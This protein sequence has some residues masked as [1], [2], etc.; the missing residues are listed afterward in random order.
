MKFRNFLVSGII[1]IKCAR[2]DFFSSGCSS[3]FTSWRR[4]TLR[5]VHE[6]N[7]ELNG[8]LID[9]GFLY[10]DFALR[11]ALEEYKEYPL[12]KMCYDIACQYIKNLVPRF[13][14]SFADFVSTVELMELFTPKLHAHGHTDNCRYQFALDFADHVGRTHGERI[15]SC[16]AEANR[17]WPEYVRDESRAPQR[18]SCYPFQRLE[19]FKK[20]FSFVG[21]QFE[22]VVLLILTRSC[23]GILGEVA[24][25][26]TS[27]F[28]RKT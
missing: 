21:R 23:S 5:D 28:R 4:G 24:N 26:R 9:P 19:I 14:K 1:A 8:V 12:I 22:Q 3:G 6:V 27:D 2:H 11:Q 16:W 15:E 10:T 25:K 13:S 7:T 20:P 17:C 18:Y